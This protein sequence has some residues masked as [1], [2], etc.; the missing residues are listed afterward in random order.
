MVEQ[1]SLS[2]ICP[3]T[4]ISLSYRSLEA[5]LST[6]GS[7]LRSITR[8]VLFLLAR[9][10]PITQSHLFLPSCYHTNSDLFQCKLLI[11]L[12]KFASLSWFPLVRSLHWFKPVY[13]PVT[14][15]HASPH[16]TKIYPSDNYHHFNLPGFEISPFSTPRCLPH[17]PLHLTL[18]QPFLDITCGPGLTDKKY[19]LTL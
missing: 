9:N 6:S 5:C 16:F 19:Y 2:P 12:N 1:R 18:S 15:S 8:P 3:S 11:H 14:H 4:I 10:K 13:F 7:S 17:C